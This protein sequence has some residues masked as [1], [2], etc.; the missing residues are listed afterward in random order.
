[1][2]TGLITHTATLVSLNDA[3]LCIETDMKEAF[4]GQSIAVS[5]CCLTVVKQNHNQLVFDLNPETLEK[6]YFKNLDHGEA[7]NLE[8]ALTL[9]STMDGHFVT[10]HV[11]CVGVI[12]SLDVF[13]NAYD[14]WVSFPMQFAKYAIVKGSIALDGISLTINEVKDN[15]C[16]IC[17]IPH[18]WTQ[19][20]LHNKQKGDPIHIEFDMMAKYFEKFMDPY[21]RKVQSL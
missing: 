20:N 12:E 17:V 16:R 8:K 14:L 5:G 2:F 9:G 13:E 4:I 7:F 3:K 18:T 6:T 10:G 11:D 19:T 21:I 15:Q 1:M